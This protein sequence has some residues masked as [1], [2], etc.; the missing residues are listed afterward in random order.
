M[1]YA[2]DDISNWKVMTPICNDNE[3]DKHK[4]LASWFIHYYC[5]TCQ[6]TSQLCWGFFLSFECLKSLIIFKNEAIKNP[7]PQLKDNISWEYQ[8][9]FC[10][11]GLNKRKIRRILANL[12]AQLRY[13]L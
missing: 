6:V 3:G 7:N 5:T 4:S 1:I 9:K 11:A 12:N 10:F 8:E 2:N 13:L